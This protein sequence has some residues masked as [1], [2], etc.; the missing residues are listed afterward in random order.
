VTPGPADETKGAAPSGSARPAERP[1]P[2]FTLLCASLAAQVHVAMGLVPNPLTGKT[3]RDLA[4]AKHGIDLLDV[5]AAKT[6]GNLDEGE[7]ALLS[8][9]LYDLRM[10]YVEMV[11]P[12]R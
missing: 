1:P 9:L 7:S 5:L 3:E 2:T 10:A 4:A 11:S 6:K 8:R 12:R